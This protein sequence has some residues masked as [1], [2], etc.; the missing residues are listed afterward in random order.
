[1]I[2]NQLEKEKFVP[3]NK[4]KKYQTGNVPWNKGIE[5]KRKINRKEV[6]SYV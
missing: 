2:E 6:N 5:W 1:M 4:G 3:W